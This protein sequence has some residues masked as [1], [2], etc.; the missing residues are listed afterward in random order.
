MD[1][2]NPS[3]PPE[4]W[5][6]LQSF[7]RPYDI[8]TFLDQT[9]YISEELDRSPLRVLHDRQC[10]CLDGGIFAA[11]AFTFIGHP[12]LLVDLTPEPG[13]DDDH[14]LAVYQFD[15]CWGAVAKSNFTGLRYREPVYRSL[16]ELAM[17]YFDDFFNVD[18]VKTM[19]GYTRPL[20]LSPFDRHFWQ[21]REDGVK[22]IARRLYQL[23]AIPILA[24]K[25][26]N[27]LEKIDPRS[28][29]AGM[30]GVNY[31]GLYKTG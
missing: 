2:N 7:K 25:M 23:K 24:D 15:G 18:G 4:L 10:H 30:L 5:D 11:L 16:R 3:I 12:P 1:P 27:R 28:Y 26:V 20:N 6:V 29:Q 22:K 17:S 31:D 19:R 9:P 21:T 13:L 14:V 8:Q